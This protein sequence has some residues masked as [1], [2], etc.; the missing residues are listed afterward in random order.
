MSIYI[1]AFPCFFYA[2]GLFL[3]ISITIYM[4]CK[5]LTG[6]G[7]CGI[8]ERVLIVFWGFVAGGVFYAF[9]WNS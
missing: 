2:S 3:T 4:G 6:H 5:G 9:T 1:Y 8:T 7:F